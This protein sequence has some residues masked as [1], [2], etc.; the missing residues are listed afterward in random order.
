M[1]QYFYLDA[2]RQQQGPIEGSQLPS[3]GVNASTLVWCNG[4]PDWTPAGQ[5]P[6]L[7]GLFAGVAPQQA[8]GAYQQ[9][10]YQ[11][12]QPAYQQPAN[13]YG[14]NQQMPCPSNNLVWAILSTLFCCLPFGIVAIVYASKVSGLY[15]SGQYDAAVDAARKAKNWSLW[16]ALACVIFWVLYFVVIVGVMGI[17]LG[18]MPS[19]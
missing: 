1:S 18:S 2:N 6:E 19:Y 12:P 5:V 14:Y 9:P 16:S 3:Y 7:A 10:A 8:P 13:P 17:A 4:M 11:Q 15:A